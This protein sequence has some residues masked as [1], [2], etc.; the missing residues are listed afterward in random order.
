MINVLPYYSL[1]L[2]STFVLRAHAMGS[3]FPYLV[4]A[5]GA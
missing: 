1:F 4:P 2:P 3:V 5:G